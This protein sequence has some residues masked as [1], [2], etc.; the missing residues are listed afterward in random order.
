MQLP[1]LR[2]AREMGWYVVAADGNPEAEGRSLCDEF[3]DVD[4]KD[5]DGLIRAAQGI[6]RRRRL[7]GVF[8]AGTDFSLS[9]ARWPGL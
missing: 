6:R 3:L 9:V 7:D 4:L 1:A 2:I 5:V 8:T